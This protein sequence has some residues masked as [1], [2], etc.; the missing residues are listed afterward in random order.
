MDFSNLLPKDVVDGIRNVAP[1]Y[2]EQMGPPK[3]IYYD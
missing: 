3:L 1:N 2:L